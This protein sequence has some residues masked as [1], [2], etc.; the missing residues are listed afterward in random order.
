[1]KSVWAD[2]V[3]RPPCLSLSLSSSFWFSSLVSE[4]IEIMLCSC[5][6]PLSQRF[7]VGQVNL[8]PEEAQSLPTQGLRPTLGEGSPFCVQYAQVLHVALT[9]LLGQGRQVTPSETWRVVASTSCTVSITA[10]GQGNGTK[11]IL[12]LFRHQDEE[13]QH[14]GPKDGTAGDKRLLHMNNQSSQKQ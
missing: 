3:L 7:L 1:M 4:T 5:S 8:I 12:W 14:Q 11:G 10:H 6:P 2:W 13:N 9:Y